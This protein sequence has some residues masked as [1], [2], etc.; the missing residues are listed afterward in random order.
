MFLVYP[1][2][3]GSAIY[4][5]GQKLYSAVTNLRKIDSRPWFEVV[6]F[7]ICCLGSI[8]A[9]GNFFLSVLS[10]ILQETVLGVKVLQCLALLH[11]S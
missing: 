11:I 5:W 3:H 8:C 1:T 7:V 4:R 10:S 2:S 6:L 9:I